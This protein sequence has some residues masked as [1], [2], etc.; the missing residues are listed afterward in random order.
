M[1]KVSA[2]EAVR[3]LEAVPSLKARAALT[4]AYAAGLRMKSPVGRRMTWHAIV[5]TAEGHGVAIGTDQPVVG[6]CH[7]MRVSAEMGQHGLRPTEGGGWRRRPSQSCAMARDGTRRHWGRPVRPIAQRRPDCLPCAIWVKPIAAM[8]LTGTALHKDDYSRLGRNRSS[9][10]DLTQD[11]RLKA[12][13]KS[14]GQHPEQKGQ[15][16][17]D[18]PEAD[19][20]RTCG[21]AARLG[22]LRA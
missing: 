17:A 8:L 7:P 15:R 6:D 10:L 13:L 4:T 5:L 22:N 2:D 12:G 16:E 14:G 19:P 9:A 3:F 18:S 11:S 1:Q 20:Q 21:S